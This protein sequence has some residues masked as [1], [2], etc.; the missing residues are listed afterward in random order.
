M[1]CVCDNAMFLYRET[2]EKVDVFTSVVTTKYIILQHQL[3][4]FK[5]RHEEN[6]QRISVRRNYVFKD[7]MRAFS[8]PKFNVAVCFVGE[9]SVDDG[10]PHRQLFQ[11]LIK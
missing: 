8:K 10:G 4:V 11:L 2:E 7:A 3:L 6:K 1:L 9:P 5:S